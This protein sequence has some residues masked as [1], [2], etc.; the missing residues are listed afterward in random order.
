MP[1]ASS[2]SSSARLSSRARWPAPWR[3]RTIASGCAW[4]QVGLAA[5]DA[6]HDGQPYALSPDRVRAGQD[7]PGLRRSS[8]AKKCS[9]SGLFMRSSSP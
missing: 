1:P 8:A 3:Y 5:V 9:A 6:V 2:E 7:V 4:S